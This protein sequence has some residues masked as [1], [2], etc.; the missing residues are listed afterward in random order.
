MESRGQHA[1]DGHRAI[2]QVEHL[3]DCT[4]RLAE[5]SYR[6][7]FTHYRHGGFR[8][9]FV[10]R[11]QAARDGH[12]LEDIREPGICAVRR[13]ELGLTSG[14]DWQI[15]ADVACRGTKG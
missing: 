11:D 7:A 5:V 12:Q 14:L 13:H 1:Y 9:E 6:K 4:T 15:A 10:R 3:T 8:P 2:F